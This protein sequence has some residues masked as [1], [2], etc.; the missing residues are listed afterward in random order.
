M[1]IE[2]ATNSVFH[3]S[4][5]N[6]IHIFMNSAL[7]YSSHRNPSAHLHMT[8]GHIVFATNGTSFG[9]WV[10]QNKYSRASIYTVWDTAVR[11]S[12][13]DAK[14]RNFKPNR[15]IIW[16]NQGMFLPLIPHMLLNLWSYLLYWFLKWSLKGLFKMN[17]LCNCDI[18]PTWKYSL[19]T[20]F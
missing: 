13:C 7:P 20:L 11:E 8:L 9:I 16:T 6:K 5:Y 18:I 3:T 4:S 15:S 19:H 17:I 14:T 1:S 2:L 12:L 10:F